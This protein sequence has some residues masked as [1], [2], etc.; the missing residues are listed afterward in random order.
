MS[1]AAKPRSKPAT[2]RTASPERASRARQRLR[3]IDACISA[4]YEHGP[5]RTT[6]DKVVSIAEMSPG[7]VNFYFETKAALLVACLEHLAQEFEMQVM[8]PVQASQSDP[9]AALDRLVE[10][11]LDPEIASPRKVSVWYAFWGEAT[12]RAEYTAICGKRD[13]AFAEMVRSLIAARIAA[14]K[15]RDVDAD[16]VALGLIGCLEMLWQEIA[17]RDECDIDRAGQRRRGQAYLRSVFPPRGVMASAAPPAPLPASIHGH[18][19]ILAGQL[20]LAGVDAAPLHTVSGECYLLA[21]PPNPARKAYSSAPH[22]P[23][24]AP[25]KLRL[26]IS[27]DLTGSPLS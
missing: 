12:S 1:Q 27:Q 6:I 3:L 20:S 19:L 21:H 11:Y 10:L 26:A 15:D 25:S 8:R 13:L 14:R 22:A 7:I 5:S 23:A 4:L 16:A 24:I 18:D 17:F 2:K 9:A